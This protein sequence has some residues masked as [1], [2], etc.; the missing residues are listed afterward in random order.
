MHFVKQNKQ[1]EG[2]CSFPLGEKQDNKNC[3][4]FEKYLSRAMYLVK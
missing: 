3:Y 2:V 4:S 1:L